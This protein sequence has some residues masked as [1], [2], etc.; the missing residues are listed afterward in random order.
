M[1][2]ELGDMRGLSSPVW[3]RHSSSSLVR[4]SRFFSLLSFSTCTCR[5]AF[6]SESCLG[7]KRDGEES[8]D[9]YLVLLLHSFQ[10]QKSDISSCKVAVLT[11]VLYSD[12]KTVG[13]APRLTL[14][15][16]VFAK[17]CSPWTLDVGVTLYYTI[18]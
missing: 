10:R 15:K 18:V 7:R 2:E 14:P 5:L 6:S 11:S 4:L 13:Y 1:G 9:R 3:R 12:G 8:K 16:A 17:N